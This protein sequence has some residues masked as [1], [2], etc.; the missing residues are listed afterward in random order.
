LGVE[1]GLVLNLFPGPT[2]P[3]QLSRVKN[4][5]R[6]QMASPTLSVVIPAYNAARHLQACIAS[7]ATGGPLTEEIIVAD[8]GSNDETSRIAA[9]QG[10][11]FVSSPKG[12]GAQLARGAEAAR[13]GW[14]LFLHADT[15]LRPGWAEAARNHM[16]NNPGMAGYFQFALN[17]PDPRARRLERVVAWRCRRLGLPY[18]DQGLLIHREL[19]AKIGG[20]PQIPLMEDVALARRIGRPRLAP[21]PAPALTSA[22]KWER[23][24]WRRRSARNL[25][26]LVLYFAGLPPALIAKL[27]G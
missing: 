16:S 7:V 23:E 4:I 10:A 21:L 8:G 26:C 24:G 3:S 19:L 20:I 1:H 17:S 6:T 27:Y 12:R 9:A 11:V 15:V 13:A 5:I 25:L 2:L 22:E 18:G 14:L